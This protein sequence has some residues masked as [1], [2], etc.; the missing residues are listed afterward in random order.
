LP[1]C[2][3]LRV[4]EL[5]GDVRETGLDRCQFVLSD[6]PGDH[7]F[8]PRRGIESPAGA[9]LRKRDRERPVLVADDERLP[10]GRV[11]VNRHFSPT[12]TRNTS[13]FLRPV[14]GSDDAINSR[15]SGPKMADSS[16]RFPALTAAMSAWTASFGAA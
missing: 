4:A 10:C 14:A 8:L 2:P 5:R 1:S 16:S 9:L 12:A 6:P 3:V 15:A 11:V 7:L 13:R